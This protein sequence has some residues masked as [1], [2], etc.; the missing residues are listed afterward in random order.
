MIYAELNQVIQTK[1]RRENSISTEALRHLVRRQSEFPL[2]PANP[3]PSVF[4]P[5]ELVPVPHDLAEARE[6][7]IDV[8]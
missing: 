4:N 6:E 7:D 5:S 2:P 3:A 1:L 8:L